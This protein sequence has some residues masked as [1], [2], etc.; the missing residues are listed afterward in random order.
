MKKKVIILLLIIL[1]GILLIATGISYAANDVVPTASN[2]IKIYV[3]SRS[4]LVPLDSGYMRVFYD[5]NNNNVGVEYYDDNFNILSKRKIDLELDIWGGFYAG[6]DAY[7]VVVGQENTEE[8]DSAEVIRVIKY[9][10]N[11]NRLGAAKIT[12]DPSDSYKQIRTPFD[13][14]CIEMKEV[15][16]NLYI[17]TGR[18]GYVDPGVGRGHQ[19]FLMIKVNESTLQGEI[20]DADLWHSFSQYIDYKDSNLYV[21]EQSEGSRQTQVSKYDVNTL[22]KT[23]IPVLEYG[24]DRTSV[25]A[26]ACYASVDGM[27]LSSNN[28]LSIGTSIDQSQYDNVT[29]DTAHNIYLTVTP[30]DNFTKEATTVKWLTDYE[31]EGQCFTGLQITKINDNRF[32][33]SWEEYGASQAITDNDTLSTNILHYIFIDGNGNKLSKEYTAAATISDCQPIVKGSKVVYYSSN[34]NMV[35][36]YTIDSNTGAF[37]KVMYRVAG[38]N[39]TWSLDDGTLT[40]SGKGA[41]SVD[42]TASDHRGAL[43]DTKGTTVYYEKNVWNSIKGSVNKI[44]IEEGITSIPEEE[45]SGFS[46]VSEVILPNSMKTIEKEA[47]AYCRALRKIVMQENIETIGEDALWSGYY[48][49]DYSKKIVYATVYTTENSY[50][51]TWA[52]QND[53]SVEYIKELALTDSIT[54]TTLNVLGE[55]TTKLVVNTIPQD[56]ADYTAMKAKV[57]NEFIV[58]AYKVSTENGVCVGENELTFTVGKS[59]KGKDVVLLQKMSNGEIKS[60]TKTVDNNGK[61]TITAN[62]LSSFMIAV[63]PDDIEYLLGDVN[64]DGY[65]DIIDCSRVLLYV[66]GRTSLTA[67]Q[68]SAADVNQDGYVDISDCS[69]ILLYAKGR[70][71]SF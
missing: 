67:T 38:E 56:N 35:D 63:D 71:T 53:I 31:G 51:S 64:E 11:W 21:L 6:N 60:V 62:E 7:Y 44:N 40:I 25:W 58:G 45:F 54:G 12:S 49:Y 46:N 30:M 66:K 42:A 47:F 8:N 32:M 68:K 39:A 50:A 3:K 29:S 4:S 14:G 18:E 15:N 36:F 28:V 55:T 1:I 57:P 5:Q 27:A 20:V 69:R 59:I 17:V 48:S 52:K 22:E 9:D 33:V 19:G 34:E 23:T 24:G 70:I 61:V 43:S 16:G 10:K 26:I 37:N 41:I 13:T 65:I 2:N